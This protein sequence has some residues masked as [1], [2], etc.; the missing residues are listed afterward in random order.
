MGTVAGR[1]HVP[2]RTC[3][4][5]RSRYPKRELL[6]LVRTSVETVAVDETGK[7]P[8]RGAY[9]CKNDL[10]LG[11]PS[12]RKQIEHVLKARLSEKEWERLSDELASIA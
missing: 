1:R 6:R 8:G 4:V 3:V 7:K 5:C 10:A 11:L 9:V 2:L 12:N